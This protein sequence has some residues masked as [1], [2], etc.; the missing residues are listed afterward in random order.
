MKV[1]FIGLGLMGLPMCQN[2]L[3]NGFDLTVWNRTPKKADGLKIRGAKIASS[4]LELGKSVDVLITMVTDGR[5]VKEIL[6][7][8]QGVISKARPSLIVIDMSTIGPTSAREIGKR[9]RKKTIDFI[10]A[11][12]TGSTP[13]AKTGELTIFAGGSRD[14]FER[15]KTILE[16]MGTNIHYM[17]DIGTGQAIKLINNHLIASCI[18]ALAEGMILADIM[19]LSRKNV[20]DVLKTVPAMSDFMNLKLPNYVNNEYPLLFSAANMEKDV[21]LALKE[22]KKSNS[23]LPVLQ[24]IVKIYKKAL[25]DGLG[26]KDMSIIIK[27]LKADNI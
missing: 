12:V 10:D 20:G 25:T 13:K 3:K 2:I 4:P 8:R 11:P 23:K 21:S 1:G 27:E 17:G 6:F 26:E 24:N 7:G 22:A 16:A 18:E 15:I 14:A 5:D 9:L 19:G